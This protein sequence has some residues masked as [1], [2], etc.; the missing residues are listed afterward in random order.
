VAAG[1]SLDTVG[2]VTSGDDEGDSD[3]R[4]GR[5]RVGKDFQAVIPSLIPV[6]RKNTFKIVSICI[7]D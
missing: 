1:V 5:I 2:G 7:N 4:E 6:N 3:E